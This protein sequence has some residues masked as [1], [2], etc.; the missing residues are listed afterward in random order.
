MRATASGK[1]SLT[2]A[3]SQA[4]VYVVDDDHG[5]RKSL[6]WLIETLGVPVETFDSAASF[7]DAYH[8]DGPSCLVVDVVMPQMTGLELQHELRRRADEIPVIVLT[9]YGDVSTAV[10]ALKH[11]AIEFLEKPFEP[12]FLLALIRQALAEDTRRY[13]DRQEFRGVR[14]R[15]NRLTPR[16]SEVLGLVVE[17]LSSK[18]IGDRL[19]VS[20]KTVEAHRAAI[21]KTMEVRSLAELVRQVVGILPAP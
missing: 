21:T 14:Q 15:L 2:P 18:Q 13:R 4:K 12:E 7:L 11:G 8:P 20:S 10:D 1:S 9:A 17:G 5:M 19:H 3:I 6:R 16:Q